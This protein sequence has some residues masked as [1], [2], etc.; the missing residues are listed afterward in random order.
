MAVIRFEGPQIIGGLEVQPVPGIHPEEAAQPGGGVGRDGPAAG[1]D[2]A[3]P[4]L[5]DA[6]GLGGRQLRDAQ[7]FEEFLAQNDAGMGGGKFGAH[8]RCPIWTEVKGK[9]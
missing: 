2:L 5:R 9:A 6:G 4:A 1:E 8:G 3:E 7:G